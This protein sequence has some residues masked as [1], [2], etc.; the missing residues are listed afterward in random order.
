[1]E[2][3]FGRRR[4]ISPRKERERDGGGEGVRGEAKVPSRSNKNIYI[5]FSSERPR[6]G[7]VVGRGGE[8]W[9]DRRWTGIKQIIFPPRGGNP[10]W[11]QSARAR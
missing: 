10:L 4:K 6:E 8:W 11:H 7:N 1:M 3:D 5:A 9:S 2:K